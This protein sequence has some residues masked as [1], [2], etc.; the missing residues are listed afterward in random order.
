MELKKQQSG[1]E[2]NDYWQYIPT[3][4]PI[5]IIGIKQTAKRL[6]VRKSQI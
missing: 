4:V 3:E 2:Y 6:S 5:S 1:A